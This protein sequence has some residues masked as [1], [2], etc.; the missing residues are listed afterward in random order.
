MVRYK[1]KSQNELD[2]KFD[3]IHCFSGG[4]LYYYNLKKINVISERIIYDSGPMFPTPD[5]VSNYI[6]NY[7]NLM[8][9]KK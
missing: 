2:K 9:I 4:S 7:Y 8:T 1:K 5:C 3:V 6:I